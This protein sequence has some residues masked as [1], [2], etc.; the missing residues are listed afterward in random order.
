MP[1]DDLSGAA[2]LAKTGIQ[3][4]VDG[5]A[6]EQNFQCQKANLPSAVDRHLAMGNS[7]LSI[8]LSDD[9]IVACEVYNQEMSGGSFASVLPFG[10]PPNINENVKPRER[11]F[12]C[13][14]FQFTPLR[15]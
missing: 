3:A 15:K 12:L 7:H 10:L 6:F 4:Q 11:R 1:V 2:A 13:N 8:R 9:R 14:R 5:L